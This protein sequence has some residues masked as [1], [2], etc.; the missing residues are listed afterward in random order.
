MYGLD[1]LSSWLYDDTK[2]FCEVQLLEG[3]EF[4]KKAWKRDILRS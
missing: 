3:F 4:L 1:I 2:P